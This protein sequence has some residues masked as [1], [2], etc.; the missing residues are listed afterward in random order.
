M[1]YDAGSPHAVRL[2]GVSGGDSRGLCCGVARGG[3]RVGGIPEIVF[4]EAG[5]LVEKG[6][7]EELTARM[8]T[9]SEDEHAHQ[10]ACQAALEMRER[11]SSGRWSE[12]FVH[13]AKEPEGEFP[14][15]T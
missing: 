4:P 10:Q 9:W 12:Q 2:G 14:V 13:W 11:F 3:I 1:E 15:L 8:R 5:Q 7:A 6:N